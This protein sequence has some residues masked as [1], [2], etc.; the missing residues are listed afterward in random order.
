MT[1]LELSSLSSPAQDLR[2]ARAFRRAFNACS[3]ALIAYRRILI[4]SANRF[5]LLPF[6]LYLP[7]P[8][9]IDS[10]SEWF[11]AVEDTPPEDRPGEY[12]GV[13]LLSTVNISII[14]ESLGMGT[15]TTS[16]WRFLLF[17]I[18]FGNVYPLFSCHTTKTL[19]EKAG[20]SLKSLSYFACGR[21][22]E[23]A[24]VRFGLKRLH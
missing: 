14:L 12:P 9:D 11:E 7:M 23:S 2:A 10:E 13:E 21:Y 24:P 22:A 3:W 16:Q 5:T 4:T 6:F 18:G 19:F 17:A 8:S 1:S 15:L 20:T